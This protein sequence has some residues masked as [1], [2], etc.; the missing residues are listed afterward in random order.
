MATCYYGGPCYCVINRQL[1]TWCSMIPYP[2]NSLELSAV[3]ISPL[4]LFAHR[5]MPHVTPFPKKTACSL[6]QNTSQAIIN[7]PSFSDSDASTLQQPLPVYVALPSVDM[8]FFQY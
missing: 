5:V 2:Q 7:L 6:P 8:N 3:I 4:S 1:K